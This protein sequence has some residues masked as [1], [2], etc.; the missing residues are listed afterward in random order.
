MTGC[1]KKKPDDDA[2]R[3]TLPGS[4]SFKPREQLPADKIEDDT[5]IYATPL[6][7]ILRF[8]PVAS[9]DDPRGSFVEYKHV[10]KNKNLEADRWVVADRGKWFVQDGQ[11]T[12]QL[13]GKANRDF[14]VV[15]L[16]ARTL[17]VAGPLYACKNGCV[18]DPIAQLPDA[19]Q[20]LPK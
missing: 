12:L 13:D 9:K 2:I 17:R 14:S 3:S 10:P 11:V 4:W 8:G 15:G 7:D 19:V 16:S 6:E 1:S 18:L 20:T 5:G